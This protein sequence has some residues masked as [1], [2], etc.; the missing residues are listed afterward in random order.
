ME[1]LY[2]IE[3]SD[4]RYTVEMNFDNIQANV[5]YRK[6]GIL[7]LLTPSLSAEIRKAN[8]YCEH[9]IYACFINSIKS[10]CKLN[11]SSGGFLILQINIDEHNSEYLIDYKFKGLDVFVAAQ[12]S[13]NPYKNGY[14]INFDWYQRWR[15]EKLYDML[16]NGSVEWKMSLFKSDIVLKIIKASKV[17]DSSY[18]DINSLFRK[19]IQKI[20]IINLEQVIRNQGHLYV[21]QTLML[22]EQR[23]ISYIQAVWLFDKKRRYKSL[24]GL[25]SKDLI[26]LLCGY[27]RL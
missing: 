10:P 16:N 13:N 9:K 19:A 24:F 18:H 17:D 7:A 22:I 1:E 2:P 12:L 26:R 20:P 8:M 5:P 15:M 27:C 3:L 21:Y 4:Q 23:P 6:Y 11:V 25:L 14:S